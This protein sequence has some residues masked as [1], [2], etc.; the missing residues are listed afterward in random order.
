M[1]FLLILSFGNT[2]VIFLTTFKEVVL[3][4]AFKEAL[5]DLLFLSLPL[6]F[7]CSPVVFPFINFPPFSAP[8]PWA[9][10]S[11]PIVLT[12]NTYSY[13]SNMHLYFS[14]SFYFYLLTW[15]SL[16]I[17]TTSSSNPNSP[18]QNW[19]V[20]LHC[21]PHSS[22]GK[23]YSHHTLPPK[24]VPSCTLIPVTYSILLPYP[25]FKTSVSIGLL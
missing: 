3:K 13:H 9:I 12:I 14:N 22:H 11:S 1:L 18:P 23:L 16:P 4:E 17:W 2:L 10:S 19:T 21:I 8:A 25:T 7:S 6:Y 20:K 15:V 5:Q 24:L